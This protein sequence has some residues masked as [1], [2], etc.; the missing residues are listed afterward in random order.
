MWFVIVLVVVLSGC[1][2]HGSTDSEPLVDEILASDGS[3]VCSFET[4]FRGEP[5]TQTTILSN[6][7]IHLKTPSPQFGIRSVWMTEDRMMRKPIEHEA[8]LG[9]DSRFVSLLAENGCDL[10]YI[11]SSGHGY[12]FF[13][14][15]QGSQTDPSARALYSLLTT[16]NLTIPALVESVA[17]EELVCSQVPLYPLGRVCEVA[18]ANEI[19]SSLKSDP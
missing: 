12:P 11:D 7:Y 18:E 16:R 5:F 15:S 9:E 6:E 8:F 14:E 3:V 1:S 13:L 4:H 17:L 2:S 10:V 19:L